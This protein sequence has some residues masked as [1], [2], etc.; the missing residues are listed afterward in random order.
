MG[1]TT[2]NAIGYGVVAFLVGLGI[3]AYFILQNRMVPSPPTLG[4]RADLSLQDGINQYRKGEYEQA[5]LFL[6]NVVNASWDHR[7]KSTASLYLG[8]IAYRKGNLDEAIQFFRESISFN[9]E[10]LFAYYNAALVFTKTGDLQKALR[11]AKDAVDLSGEDSRAGLLLANI[12]FSA[13]RLHKASQLYGKLTYE[14]GISQYN[15]ALA[16]LREGERSE[17]L[18]ILQKGASDQ[19]QDALLKALSS[20]TA[21]TVGSDM[22]TEAA[23]LPAGKASA[24]MEQAFVMFNSHPSIYYN[25]VLLLLREGKYLETIELLQSYRADSALKP[26]LGYALYKHGDHLEALP[27]WEDLFDNNDGDAR[28]A[29]VLGDIHYHLGNWDEAASYYQMAAHS[30]QVVEAYG[31]LVQTY[32]QTGEFEKAFL[33]CEA[34]AEAAGEDVNPL[35]CLADL[36]FYTGPRKQAMNAVE[37]A[38]GLIGDDEDG[39]ESVAALY[40][41]HGMYN[42][43]L[44]LYGRILSK[45]PQR[46]DIHGKIAEIYLHAGQNTRAR[47]E[48]HLLLK[49]EE[50]SDILYRTAI[51]LAGVE[52]GAK[53]KGRLN[54]LMLDF[55]DR[56]EAFYNTAVLFF[57]EGEYRET[58]EI[59]E[60]YLEQEWRL[61]GKDA[62]LMHTLSGVASARLGMEDRAALHFSKAVELDNDNELAALNLKLVQEYPF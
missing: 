10:N 49:Q 19:K 62:S 52:G 7:A 8:N 44:R 41:R 60:G 30:G 29:Q 53:G 4:G 39:L 50:N 24:H 17:A 15:L 22:Q 13:G 51:L 31:S 45:N 42:S 6:T 35:L 61:D 48:L 1:K 5:R 25:H 27:I 59:V 11:Y 56:Y 16:L 12:Y 40:A 3:L 21:A 26:L 34:Y 36:Y 9:D 23:L 2:R 54:K 14:T 57:Q 38:V 43:S 20:Y 18:H 55:P 37:K 33:A 28:I 46:G 47:D 32:V 58:L